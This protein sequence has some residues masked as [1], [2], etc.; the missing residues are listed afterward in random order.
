MINPTCVFA[1]IF[2]G[3][4]FNLSVRCSLTS[5]KVD[6]VQSSKMIIIIIWWYYYDHRC[7]YST[8]KEK[9]FPDKRWLCLCT[10]FLLIFWE[11]IFKVLINFL[12]IFLVVF[13]IKNLSPLVFCSWFLSTFADKASSV[14]TKCV[15]KKR[16]GKSPIKSSHLPCFKKTKNIEMKSKIIVSSES[17]LPYFTA[18]FVSAR[19]FAVWRTFTFG[20]RLI[21]SDLQI[22]YL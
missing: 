21:T 19:D 14:L 15:Q 17:H 13:L 9:L 10:L 7:Y 22:V 1:F 20:F 4:K 3:H 18:P 2:L 16:N 5:R 6:H 12:S 8:K 11:W